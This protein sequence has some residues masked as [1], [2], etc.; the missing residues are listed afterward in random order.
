MKKAILSVVLIFLFA[1]IGTACDSSSDVVADP[2]GI[3]KAEFEQLM[4][5]MS[6]SKVKSIIGGLGELV[7]EKENDTDEYFETVY[8]YKVNG[9]TT[10]YAELEITYHKDKEVLSKA[11]YRLTGK[12]QYD[13]S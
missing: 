8:L 1:I 4:T 13:L 10:G 6:E 5:G 12:T 2:S 3:S 7:S 11:E 9:E